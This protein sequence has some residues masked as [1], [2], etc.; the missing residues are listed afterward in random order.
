[1]TTAESILRDKSKDDHLFDTVYSYSNVGDTFYIVILK[2]KSHRLVYHKKYY[3]IDW[4][5]Q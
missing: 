4:I 3:E 1:M 5:N 2:P